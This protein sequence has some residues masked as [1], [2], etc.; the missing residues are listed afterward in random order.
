MVK[1][2]QSFISLSELRWF[3]SKRAD[4]P[5]SDMTIWEGVIWILKNEG[6]SKDLTE[7]Y[8]HLICQTEFDSYKEI[9]RLYMNDEIEFYHHDGSPYGYEAVGA[10]KNPELGAICLNPSDAAEVLMLLNRQRYRVISKLHAPHFIF[11][12]LYT[13]II[14]SATGEQSMMTVREYLSGEEFNDVIHSAVFTVASI[15]K[16]KALVKENQMDDLESQLFSATRPKRGYEKNLEPN[17]VCVL[18]ELLS[19][20]LS[21][22]LR[23]QNG[24]INFSAVSKLLCLNVVKS[25]DLP[26]PNTLEKSL[27]DMFKNDALLMRGDVYLADR[28]SYAEIIDGPLDMRTKK[29][30]PIRPKFLVAPMSSKSKG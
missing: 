23:K 28:D 30:G 29:V 3:S 4:N 12:M 14:R 25:V 22:V 7:K 15:K 20:I 26:K 27:K 11:S 10:L 17:L 8:Y 21:G 9:E 13:E 19:K 1:G 5:G 16:W 6:F 2:E 24:G 18:V